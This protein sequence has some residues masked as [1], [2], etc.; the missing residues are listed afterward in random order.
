FKRDK[1]TCQYCGKKA[2]DVILEV[3]HIQP[4]AKGGKNDLLNLTTACIDCNRGKGARELSDGSV[5]EQQRRQLEELQERQDQIRMMI[6][7]QR[8]LVDLDGQAVESAA[9]FWCDLAD[10]RG[11]TDEGKAD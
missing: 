11:V 6:D 3:D 8:S 5:I 2:P 4:R 10:W 9:K 7:W 1:F